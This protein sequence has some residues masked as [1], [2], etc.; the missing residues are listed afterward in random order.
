MGIKSFRELEVWQLAM[1]LVAEIYRLTLRFPRNELYG[2]TSQMRRAAVS[3][4]S[5]IAEGSR[6]R[7]T[8][9]LLHYLSQALAS[10][11]ELETQIE[12]ARQL[13][14]AKDE[15]IKDVEDLA[16][17]VA[18]MLNRLSGNLERANAR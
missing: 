8:A 10:E 3:V 14:Y 18:Q 9:A 15:E 2:L 5:H 17:R 4:P 1:T 7:T 12:I 6:Q 13:R 11:A 16:V